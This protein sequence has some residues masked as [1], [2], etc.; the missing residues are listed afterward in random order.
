[1]PASDSGILTVFEEPLT[2]QPDP[3]WPDAPAF[4][5]SRPLPEYRYV[6]GVNPHPRRHADGHSYGKRLETQPL[7]QWDWQENEDFLFAIDL[8]HGAYLWESH[9]P[10]TT[11]LESS[12]PDTPESNLLQALLMNSAAQTAAF[13]NNPRRASIRSQTARWR[14]A[15]IR[16]KGFAGPENRFM[17]FD[18]SDLIDQIVRHYT[19]VWKQIENG[20][21]R[22]KGP[23]P[24]LLPEFEE[25]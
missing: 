8:Y 22:L 2:E 14:L 19:P 25:D 15:R 5:P 16:A 17:G 24:R 21:V 11:L 13:E 4:C 7:T 12:Q 23:A 3:L 9:E 1:M 18:I 6:R 10:W 20:Y